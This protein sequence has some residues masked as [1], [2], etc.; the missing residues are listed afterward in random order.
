MN[1]LANKISNPGHLKSNN[2]AKLI[3]QEIK[4]QKKY[5]KIIN[6]VI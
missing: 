4:G 2:A 1:Q 6:S 3:I 5:I